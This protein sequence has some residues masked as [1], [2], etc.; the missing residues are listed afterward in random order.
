MY[1]SFGINQ[2][3]TENTKKLKDIIDNNHNLVTKAD[4]TQQ[5]MVLTSD[6]NSHLQNLKENTTSLEMGNQLSQSQSELNNKVNILE[7]L[8][9]CKVDK[10][11]I[12]QITALA[13]KLENFSEFS[14][15]TTNSINK[16]ENDANLLIE[17][18]NKHKEN[19]EQLQ[20]QTNQNTLDI[21]NC[22]KQNVADFLKNEINN[23]NKLLEINYPNIENFNKLRNAV[24]NCENNNANQA[25]L[26][27][28]ID[29]RLINV[30]ED[31]SNKASVAD[32]KACVLR[33]HF[34]EIIT[35]LGKD[36]D[37]KASQFSFNELE[38][39]VKKMGHKLENESKRVDVSM[40]FVE[41]FSK[42]GENY[43]HNLRLVDK[44]IEKLAFAANP[45]DRIPYTGQVK[46]VG[47]NEKQQPS[48]KKV[49]QNV[50]TTN[51][52]M[53]DM[54]DNLL[55][56]HVSNISINPNNAQVNTEEK[57]KMLF[58]ELNTILNFNKVNN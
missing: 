16:L 40:R 41:W 38:N 58:Q 35:V 26:L 1:F 9:S 29:N 34:E 50:R 51:F 21:E 22:A 3:V 49:Y 33:R 6:L 57:T 36:C 30:E 2:I 19:I 43:E 42:R 47:V 52:E 46:F 13:K 14:N 11:E 12:S 54:D 18:S 32:V 48:I 44:H 53:D 20:Q 4:F 55:N 10:S 7:Q 45:K 17:M 24:N 15:Q 39:F 31:M 8:S 5:M 23:I 37:S 28:E 27:K 25:N 56:S